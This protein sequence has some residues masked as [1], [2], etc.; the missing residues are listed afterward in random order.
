[1]NKKELADALSRW[2]DVLNYW[3]SD[4]AECAERGGGMNW[5]HKYEKTQDEIYNLWQQLNKEL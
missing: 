1:M 4:V 2:L 3:D 5:Y